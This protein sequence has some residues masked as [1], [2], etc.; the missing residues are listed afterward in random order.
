MYICHTCHGALKL[1]RIPAKSKANRM[2]LDEIPDELKDLNTL[3]LHIICKR[4]L[5]MKLVKLPRGKQKG[6]RGAVVN[7]PADLGSACNIPPRLPAY[8]ARHAHK[9][10]CTVLPIYSKIQVLPGIT[11]SRLMKDNNQQLI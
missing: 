5:F 11:S 2:T 10:L 3:E 7:V 9:C 8:T 4:I 1:G 6:I